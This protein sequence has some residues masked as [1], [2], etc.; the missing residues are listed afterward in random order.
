[1]ILFEK[2]GVAP[3]AVNPV[4]INDKRSG[5]AGRRMKTVDAG[6]SSLLAQSRKER[7]A[8]IAGSGNPVPTTRRA[9]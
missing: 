3:A 5:S 7:N 4:S 1:M 9:D 2:K 8:G 6:Q